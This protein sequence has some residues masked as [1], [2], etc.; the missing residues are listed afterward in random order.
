MFLSGS[1]QLA[2]A[3]KGWRLFLAFTPNEKTIK[4]TQTMLPKGVHCSKKSDSIQVHT[5]GKWLPF[6]GLWATGMIY[7]FV[8]WPG[9]LRMY[10]GASE[11]TEG[12]IAYTLFGD[13]T[14]SKIMRRLSLERLKTHTE[15]QREGW[16]VFTKEGGRDERQSQGG[17][18]GHNLQRQGF[19][20][21][22][23]L[24]LLVKENNGESEIWWMDEK[25]R[26]KEY[27]LKKR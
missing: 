15:A 4:K 7:S 26:E 27:L 14:R 6:G 24:S 1:S 21:Q 20:F 19:R 8:S 17:K 22:T 10:G 13:W 25:R 11:K 18:K 2:T 23:E 3:S 16:E 12:C 5:H 9:L